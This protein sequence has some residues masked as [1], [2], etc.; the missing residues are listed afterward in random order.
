MFKFTL[1]AGLK[2]AT[3]VGVVTSLETVHL[4][5]EYG[6]VSWSVTNGNG[7]FTVPASVPGCAHTDLL[8]AKIIGEPNFGKNTELQ[9]WIPSENFTYSTKF[10]VPFAV[11]AKRNQDLVLV[12]LDTA[13]K[14]NVNNKTLL[15][16][17]N[18]HRAFMVDLASQLGTSNNTLVV[19]FTG[20]VPASLAA[21]AGC[22]SQYSS[23]MY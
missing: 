3:F 15:T 12:G 19:S 5:S 14:V 11:L 7:S 21:Q 1:I 9:A 17:A 23:I 8:A 22:S 18:M 2:F 13:V 4:S 6:S 20:P 10:S 16:A